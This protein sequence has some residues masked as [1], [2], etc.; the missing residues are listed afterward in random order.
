MGMGDSTGMDLSNNTNCHCDWCTY[1]ETPHR[2][3]DR[4]MSDL[5]SRQAAI[6]FICSME[7]CDEISAEAYKKLTNYLGELPSV[8]AEIIRCEDCRWWERESICEGHC[9][10][11]DL[12]YV[13]EDHYCSF[14]ERR[15]DEQ[16]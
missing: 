3:G 9:L 15:T 2:K 5:I 10:E 4:V 12:H 1:V 16:T 7:M 14:A 11:I 13:D 6:D 8:E